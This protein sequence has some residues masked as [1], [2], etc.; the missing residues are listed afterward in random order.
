MNLL[1]LQIQKEPGFRF[2]LLDFIFI[3]FLTLFSTI[4]YSFI[5]HHNYIY[6]LP[7][8]I[9]FTFFL[10]CNVFRV[11]TKMELTWI[12]F[13]FIVLFIFYTFMGNS[14]FLY[15][16]VS[17]SIFQTIIIYLTIKSYAYKGIFSKPHL[18]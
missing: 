7:L 11:T 8:Y 4:I 10:F 12:V 15:T 13:F 2:N 1:T 17:S 18:H 14:W 16:A 3:V 6:L 9:G 5:G